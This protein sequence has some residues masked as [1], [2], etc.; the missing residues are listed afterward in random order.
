MNRA[1]ICAAATLLMLLAVGCG[2]ES[3]LTISVE[4]DPPGEEAP[5]SGDPGSPTV[6]GDAN[7]SD[8]R[9]I[10]AWSKALSEGDIK[11]AAGY[12]AI[13]SVAENGPALLRIRNEGQARLFNSSLPCGAEVIRAETQG[14]FTTATFRLG[15]RPGAG[16]CGID[17]AAATAETSF[18]IEG[19]KIAEWRRVDTIAPQPPPEDVV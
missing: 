17:G 1:G 8:V 4:T 19:G 11:A 14:A 13:P 6:P 5:A 3:Q 15:E 2:G 9:V 7:A 18:V 12:F 16:F 10:V